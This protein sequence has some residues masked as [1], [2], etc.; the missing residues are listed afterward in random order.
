MIKLSIDISK[1]DKSR[2][3]KA[4]KRDGTEA[5]YLELVLFETPGSEYGDF[6]VKQQSAREERESGLQLPIIGDG[7]LF[8]RTSAARQTAPATGAG[9][10]SQAVDDSV[11]F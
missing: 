2:F 11:P 6:I 1:I 7:K 8:T 4:R 9:E 10:A 3:K 5:Q